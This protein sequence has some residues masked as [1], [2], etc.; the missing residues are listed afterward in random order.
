MLSLGTGNWTAQLFLVN[1]TDGRRSMELRF[2]SFVTKC[3]F[4]NQDNQ[5]W[6]T[7]GCVV[8]VDSEPHMTQCLCNHM[9]FYGSSFFVMPNQVDLSQTAALFAKVSENYV[10][11]VMLSAFF[12]LYLILLAWAIYADKQAFIKEP[13]LGCTER[14]PD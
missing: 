11:V 10:V 13:V 5:T 4:W 12:G 6:S 3:M 8:G 14:A 9:T 2:V 7:N 1:Y